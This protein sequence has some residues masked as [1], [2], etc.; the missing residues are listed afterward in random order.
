MALTN[1]ANWATCYIY[2]RMKLANG[3]HYS[4]ME[5]HI[6]DFVSQKGTPVASPRT[7][8][9]ASASD[10]ASAAEIESGTTIAAEWTERGQNPLSYGR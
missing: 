7:A 10:A 3:K 2:V 4:A 8:E 6:Y 9:I 1:D 5:E